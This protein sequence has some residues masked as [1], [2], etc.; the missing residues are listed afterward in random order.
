MR[1]VSKLEEHYRRKDLREALV[2]ASREQADGA[3]GN[4]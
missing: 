3:G 1:L 2:E 4:A